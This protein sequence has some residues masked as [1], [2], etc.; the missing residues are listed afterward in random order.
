M[1]MNF[2]KVTA[3]REDEVNSAAHAT[4]HKKLE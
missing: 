3:I 2:R 1:M 4:E